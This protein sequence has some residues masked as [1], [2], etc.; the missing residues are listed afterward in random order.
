MQPYLFSPDGSD[1]AEGGTEA[2]ESLAMPAAGR[3]SLSMARPY[4]VSWRDAVLDL[5]RSGPRCLGVAATGLGKTVLVPMLADALFRGALLRALAREEYRVLVIC[6]RVELVGQMVRTCRMLLPDEYVEVEQGQNRATGDCRLVV[7][8]IQSLAKKRRLGRFPRDRFAAVVWDECH[9]YREGL[10]EVDRVFAHFAPDTRHL[11]LTATPDRTDQVGLKSLFHR[12]AFEYQI[13]QGVDDG[14]L[15]RPYQ[16]YESGG[17]VRLDGCPLG[18]DG[19]FSADAMARRMEEA[20]PIAA[21]VKAA[22]K[23]SNY[24]NGRPAARKTV[25]TC[26]SVE[27]AQRTARAL[28]EWHARDGTG[29]AGWI[30]GE[31]VP[32]SPERL[33]VLEDFNSGDLRYLCHFDVL[34]EGW[35]SPAPKVIVNGRPTRSRWVY[36]QM[37][38]RALRP[39]RE[40]VAAL[41]AAPDAA[42]RLAII[43]ASAKPGAVVVDVAGLDHKLVVSLKDVFE[44]K[45][46]PLPMLPEPDRPPVP[47][48]VDPDAP[49]PAVARSARIKARDE[50]LAARWAGVRVDTA[51]TTRFADPFDVYAVVV[52]REPPWYKGRRPTER[53]RAALERAGVGK[54]E[55]AGMTFWAARRMM[56]TVRVRRERGLCS[57][58]QAAVLSRHGYDPTNL[59]FEEASRLMDRLK[60]NGWRAVEP[61]READ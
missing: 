39:D 49:D 11:G 44:G 18:A 46:A 1:W 56:E 30:S 35:D 9:R 37:A 16:V 6:H 14:W 29:R 51:L 32:G 28:N 13:Q 40:C 10:D 17:A 3:L 43:A 7:A 23:W 55:A 19:D 25:V 53:M 31:M 45:A 27:A 12:I 20:E 48:E 33:A 58:R 5:W 36:G 24:A 57:Y 2:T 21:V 26:A 34:T 15:V 54:R 38:G 59:T 4:Q 22:I 52:G 41:N 50:E 42:A 8:S 60:A 47:R 61:A